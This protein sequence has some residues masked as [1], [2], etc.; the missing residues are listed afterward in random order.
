MS[1]V[2]TA[3]LFSSDNYDT[4]IRVKDVCKQTDIN[5]LIETDFFTLFTKIGKLKPKFVFIDEGVRKLNTFPL[6]ILDNHVFNNITKLV[7]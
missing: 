6:E 4:V 1:S 3:M 2:N 7:I 5:L